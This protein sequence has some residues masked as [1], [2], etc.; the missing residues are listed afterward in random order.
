MAYS[1]TVL[2][3]LPGTGRLR[4]GTASG[5]IPFSGI[6][7]GLPLY[8]HGSTV[9][10]QEDVILRCEITD[11]A[12]VDTDLRW[13]QPLEYIGSWQI[14]DDQGIWSGRPEERGFINAEVTRFRAISNYTVTANADGNRTLADGGTINQCNLEL[15]T[16]SI[17]TPLGIT[18]SVAR[19]R[20]PN[21]LLSYRSYRDPAGLQNRS[22]FERIREVGIYL[23]PGCRAISYT[24]NIAAINNIETS[25]QIWVPKPC[26][27]GDLGC[28]LAFENFIL[29]NNGGRPID[30]IGGR[31]WSSQA[32]CDVNASTPPCPRGTFECPD[33]Q[34]TREYWTGSFDD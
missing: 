4:A 12:L 29:D 11:S 13:Y 5:L 24:K 34:G 2:F 7:S 21:N 19:P 17:Q 33:G 20:V 22:F 18:L 31:Y 27:L 9:Q 6:F 26:T 14:L 32:I 10:V 1:R 3:P 15:E 25:D 23:N 28:D 30:T 16:V 8:Y